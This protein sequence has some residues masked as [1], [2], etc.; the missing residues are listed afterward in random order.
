MGIHCFSFQPGHELADT[1][2]QLGPDCT[3]PAPNIAV[4]DEGPQQHLDQAEEKLLK[5][6][7]ANDVHAEDDSIE[8]LDT[9]L[10]AETSKNTTSGM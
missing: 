1:T 7:R 3:S 5:E 2:Q 10:A 8:A 4:I 6:A 9:R